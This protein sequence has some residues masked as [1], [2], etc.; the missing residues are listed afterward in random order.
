M[1]KLFNK[2]TSGSHGYQRVPQPLCEM[3]DLQHCP[4]EVQFYNYE[5]LK[6]TV[7]PQT[8]FEIDKIVRTRNKGG[9]KQYLVKWRGY[10]E[11]FK[12]CVNASD[13]KKI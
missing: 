7:L 2:D 10:D 6:V 1:N 12:S 8:E 13:I 3:S 4:I 9:I 11:T 5:L